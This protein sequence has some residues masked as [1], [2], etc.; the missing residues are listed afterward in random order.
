MPLLTHQRMS[1]KKASPGYSAAFD[2]Q[3]HDRIARV[4]LQDMLVF[5]DA[6]NQEIDKLHHAGGDISQY[7][8]LLE[9]MVAVREKY[10]HAMCNLRE[11]KNNRECQALIAYADAI[12]DLMVYLHQQRKH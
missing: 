9:K 8:A 6:L 7:Q 4:C 10:S 1:R 12:Q 3:K 11:S 2:E 5:H